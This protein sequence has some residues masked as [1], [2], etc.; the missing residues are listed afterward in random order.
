MVYTQ[1]CVSGIIILHFMADLL[2]PSTV[3][4][5]YKAVPK[6]KF[7]LSPRCP[8]S[9]SHTHTHTQFLFWRE[10]RYFQL[11]CG[12]DLVGVALEN[13]TIFTLWPCLQTTGD[14]N[15]ASR[16]SRTRDTVKL[17]VCVC[18]C[19]CVCVY[20]SC[21]WSTVAMQQKLTASIGF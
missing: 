7:V 10:L 1:F 9:L 17:T 21:N 19:V 5:V 4:L 18:V 14:Y 13:S 12:T 11:M 15:Y 8:C 3:I 6:V 16:R 2:D 20:S